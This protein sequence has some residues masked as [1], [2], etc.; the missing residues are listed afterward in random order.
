MCVCVCV[1]GGLRDVITNRCVM[2]RVSCEFAWLIH[3]GVFY[4]VRIVFKNSLAFVFLKRAQK[5][6]ACLLLRKTWVLGE[7][8][9]RKGDRTDGDR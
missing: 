8:S 2:G 5:R 4:E 9:W 3:I 6:Q 1:C 7:S